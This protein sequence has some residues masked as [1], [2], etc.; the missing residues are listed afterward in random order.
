MHHAV[1]EAR[2]AARLALLPHLSERAQVQQTRVRG[3]R[4]VKLATLCPCVFL[5]CVRRCVRSGAS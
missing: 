3:T 2:A 5:F 4:L 1:K